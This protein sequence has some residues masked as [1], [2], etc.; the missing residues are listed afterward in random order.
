MN[1]TKTKR[2]GSPRHAIALAMVLALP[3][4]AC[5]SDEDSGDSSADVPSSTEGNSTEQ[6]QTDASTSV[7]DACRGQ[8]GEGRTIG[9]ANLGEDVPFAVTIRENLEDL[10]ERCNLKVVN[11]DN[12]LSPEVAMDNARNF[13]TQG[14]D[15]VVEFQ[16]A[17]DISG[18][19]CE[20]LGDTPV[21][22]I[23][24]AHPEC[25]VFMGADNFHAG[26]INGSGVGEVAKDQWS[27]DLDAVL[28]LENFGV[29]QV[30]IDRQNGSIA[31]LESVCPDNEFGDYQD[32]SPE[33]PG[34]IVT[35]LDACLLYT[36]PSPR[37]RTRSRMPSSA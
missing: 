33:H 19:L 25:A 12:Q 27:C 17:A 23:D 36:S 6:T 20:V 15:G 3:V 28:S 14:V 9:F 11:A 2:R 13:M 24:I 30:N 32:W 31:G 35:R 29:G 34:T 18:A 7:D 5:G 21:I 37:D 26:E 16:I 1:I 22:A 10:A 8:D 4:A